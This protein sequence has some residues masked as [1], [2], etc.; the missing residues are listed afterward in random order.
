MSGQSKMAK[1][2]S[3]RYVVVRSGARA[4]RRSN[5]L[6]NMKPISSTPYPEVNKIL[7]V[8]L[9]RVGEILQ[10][11][12][13]GMYLHGSLANGGFDEYSDI[14][15]VIVTA[16]HISEEIFTTLRQMHEQVAKIDSPWAVQLEVS[17]IPVNALRRFDPEDK[18]YSHLDRGKDEI[19]H[20]MSHESDWIVQR[21]LLREHGIVITGP[22]PKALIDPVSPDDLRQAVANVLPLWANPALDDPSQIKKRGYQSFFVLSLCR[23]LY[24][25]RYGDVISKSEAASWAMDTLDPEWKPLI[26][27]ALIGRQNPDREAEMQD[28]QGTLDMMRFTLEQVK[29]TPYQ[30]VNEVLCLLLIHVKEILGEQFVGMYLYGSLSGGDFNPETSDIDFLVVTANVLSDEIT[31]QLETMH[32]Q[33]WATGLKWAGKLEGA[34]VPSE[35]I[36]RHDLDGTACP[37]VNEGQF[38]VAKL[39]SDWIIQ[40]HVIR[41]NGV[42]MEGPDPKTLIDF[43]GPDEIRRSVKGVLEE[44]WF[45]MREDPAWLTA[46]GGNYHSFAILTMCRALHALEHG[47]II[48]KPAAARWAQDKLGERWRRVIEQAL[49]PQMPGEGVN[50][51][52]DALELIGYTRKTLQV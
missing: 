15:V 47:T 49:D 3:G 46:C 52:E 39:G 41:E 40:R 13:I 43:V 22:D 9:R 31:S 42:V 34:Y 20:M 30:E 24:T 32:K 11:Q 5:L 28:I 19:L 16:S 23:M 8:L 38:Y 6:I 12:L 35:L 27:R 33:L 2:T 25:L 4:R 10:D 29:P 17:Y 26:Q 48:S 1:W 51:L 7:D 14:D 37:T 45:P 50:L 21:H 36:R 44:W 18:V